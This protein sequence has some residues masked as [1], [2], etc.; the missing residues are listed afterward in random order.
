[1][2]SHKWRNHR[3]LIPIKVRTVH[4]NRIT[5]ALRCR[6]LSSSTVLLCTMLLSVCHRSSSTVLLHTM[7][8][9][10]RNLRNLIMATK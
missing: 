5:P 10:A 3:S 7:L 8:L 1:M 9:S 6:Q 4:N 2:R